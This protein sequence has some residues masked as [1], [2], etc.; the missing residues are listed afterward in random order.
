[1]SI[2]LPSVWMSWVLDQSEKVGFAMRGSE[3]RLGKSPGADVVLL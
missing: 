3:F 1:M 2:P